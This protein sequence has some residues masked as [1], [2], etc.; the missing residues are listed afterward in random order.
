AAELFLM[1]DGVL[2]ACDPRL[3]QLLD[4]GAEVA[5]CAT[6]AEARGVAPAERGPRFGSQWDHACMIRDARTIV[7][8]TGVRPARSEPPDGPSRRVAV[9]LTRDARHPKTAQALRSAIGYASAR[10]D[11]R[12]VVG[13]KARALVEHHDHPRDLLRALATLRALGC[14]LGPEPASADVEVVW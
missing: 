13:L 1:D 2:A 12:V 8:L 14:P 3:L 4:E 5:L 7:A 9:H 10:L 11:V 6:D